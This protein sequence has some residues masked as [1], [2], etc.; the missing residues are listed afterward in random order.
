MSEPTARQ[1]LIDAVWGPLDEH[2]R[3]GTQPALPKRSPWRRARDVLVAT[4]TVATIAGVG[5]V[6]LGVTGVVFGGVF[7]ATAARMR[8]RAMAHRRHPPGGG[9]DLFAAPVFAKGRILRAEPVMSPTS[10][11]ACA[12][13]GLELRYVGEWGT[14]IILRA[15][16]TEGVTIRLD[17]G[18]DVRLPAGPIWLAG[19]LPQVDDFDVTSFEAFMRMVDPARAPGAE[20]WPPLPHNVVVED[21]LHVGDRVELSGRFEPAISTAPAGNGGLYRDAP[22]TVLVPR[23]L[24]TLRRL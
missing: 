12:A 5:W 17:D 11:Q 19:E 8:Q 16:F 9:K 22:T 1:R 21:S 4:T 6:V 13:W 3:R 20:L 24:A 18:G 23:S 10:G 7:S 14:A 2:G 15:G